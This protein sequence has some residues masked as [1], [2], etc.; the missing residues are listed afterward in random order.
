MLFLFTEKKIDFR[1]TWVAKLVERLT[2]GFGSGHNLM[3]CGIEPSVRL[4]AQQ[5]VYLKILFLC[6]PSQLSLSFSSKLINLKRNTLFFQ[7]SFRFT[8]K[9]SGRYRDFLSTLC[10]STCTGKNFSI[11]NIPL[12]RGTFVAVD[13]P[14]L[15]H[16]YY[17]EYMVYMRVHS[18]CYFHSL[19]IG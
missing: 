2:F 14:T 1:G 17:S 10:L 18:W 19:F 6:F 13:V 8:T 5:G 11:I 4:H 3:G 7:K 12:Q 16:H 9:L 15:T